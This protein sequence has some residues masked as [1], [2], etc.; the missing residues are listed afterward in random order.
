MLKQLLI[1]RIVKPCEYQCDNN[2]YYFLN[3]Q[4][5]KSKLSPLSVEVIARDQKWIEEQKMGAFLSVSQGS[6]QVP[7]FLEMT[8]NNAPTDTGNY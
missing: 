4:E 5:V 3:F 6:A 2:F 1:S 7:I 8:L